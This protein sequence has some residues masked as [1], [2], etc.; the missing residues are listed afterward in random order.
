V[1]EVNRDWYK[2]SYSGSGNCVEV[3]WG[4]DVHVRDSKNTGGQHLSIERT[5]WMAFV[6]GVA[7]GEFDLEPTGAE[8]FKS[9]DLT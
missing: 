6:Q 3:R 7:D 9:R 8:R 4:T 5:A 1:S 2:S